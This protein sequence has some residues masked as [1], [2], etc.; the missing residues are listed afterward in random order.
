MRELSVR[1]SNWFNVFYAIRGYCV[2]HI[3]RY[4][5]NII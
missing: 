3:I 4:V 5:L 2:Q 1:E